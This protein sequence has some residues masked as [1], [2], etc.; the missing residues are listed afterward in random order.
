MIQIFKSLGWHALKDRRQEAIL[1][2]LYKITMGL[3][4][5]NQD[6]YL[7]K[8]E[9]RTHSTNNMKFPIIQTSAMQY[10]NS[11]FPWTIPQWNA[12]PHDTIDCSSPE[13]YRAALHK[14]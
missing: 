4:T 10:Y 9:S 13:K 14:H 11:F 6:D 8:G 7:T 2:L 5:V 1:A 3:V 12:S